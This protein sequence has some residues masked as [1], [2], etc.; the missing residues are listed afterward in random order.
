MATPTAIEA[1]VELRMSPVPTHNGKDEIKS[2]VPTPPTSEDLNKHDELNSSD[3]SDIEDMD[4]ELDDGDL[5]DIKP[6][7]YWDEENGGKIP[8]FKPVC[9]MRWRWWCTMMQPCGTEH[10]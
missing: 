9:A 2:S 3:L 6:D 10:H 4:N 5:D 1:H 8:V 7:H